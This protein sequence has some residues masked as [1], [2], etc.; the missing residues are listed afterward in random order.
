MD[1]R[2]EEEGAQGREG[3]RRRGAGAAMLEV[4]AELGKGNS[5]AE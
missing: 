3:E 4:P 5:V 1:G 2:G